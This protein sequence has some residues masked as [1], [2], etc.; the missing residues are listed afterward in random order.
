MIHITLISGLWTGPGQ[1]EDIDPVEN[2]EAMERYI[3]RRRREFYKEWNEYQEK[4]YE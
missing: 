3:E 1:E 4:A 2:D